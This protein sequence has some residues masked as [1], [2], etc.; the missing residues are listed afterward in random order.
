MNQKHIL[1]VCKQVD[2]KG[3]KNM[4]ETC[5]WHLWVTDSSKKSTKHISQ[6]Q[7]SALYVN[8]ATGALISELRDN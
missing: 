6:S 3:D 1:S 7:L 2:Y 5:L 8:T 4:T